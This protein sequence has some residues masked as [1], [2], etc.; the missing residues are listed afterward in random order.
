MRSRVQDMHP[1]HY[2]AF[3]VQ[4]SKNQITKLPQAFSVAE[5]ISVQWPHQI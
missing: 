3:K 2:H 1:L 5:L 4:S